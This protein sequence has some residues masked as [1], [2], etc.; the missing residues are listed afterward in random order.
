M[1]R[2]LQSTSATAPLCLH[3]CPSSGDD[4]ECDTDLYSS[5][6]DLE[7][8][9]DLYFLPSCGIGFS[10]L[11]RI[12]AHQNF[13]GV[14]NLTRGRHIL[15]TKGR[16]CVCRR[17]QHGRRRLFAFQL[18]RQ[19]FQETKISLLSQLL[20]YHSNPQST[21]SHTTPSSPRFLS[22]TPS[23]P[24]HTFLTGKR[25]GPANNHVG[26]NKKKHKPP[27]PPPPVRALQGLTLNIRGMTPAKWAAIQELP[28]FST[29]DYLTEHQLSAE[30]RVDEIFKSGWDFHA[31]SVRMVFRF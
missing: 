25:T 8:D 29:L 23:I 15:T 19:Q 24:A 1:P 12:L 11:Q 26:N 16:L 4:L 20:Q 17:S 2:S 27:P 30:F 9:T 21:L 7:C 22:A 28:V 14:R 13:R 31:V 10:L 5:G 18:P 6:D 3:T